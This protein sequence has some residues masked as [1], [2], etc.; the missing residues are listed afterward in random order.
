MSTRLSETE[1]RR[2]RE[3]ALRHLFLSDQ[4]GPQVLLSVGAQPGAGK[5]RAIEEVRAAFY[6]N[7]DL[8]PVIGDDLRAY[9]PD[10][11]RLVRDPDPLAMPA[12]T[13]DLS[14]WLVGQALDWA[15]EHGHSVLV[16]GTL[17]R[18]GTT[19][20]TLERFHSAGAIT[21][22]VVL[23]VPEA[24][25]WIGCL[26]RYLTSLARDGAARWTPQEAHDAGYTGTPATLA[27]A[28]A[29]AAVHRLSVV[30][31]T[32]PSPMTAPAT[33]QTGLGP[34]R[35]CGLWRSCAP[36][37]S[38]SAGQRPA[39]SSLS[40]SPPT[41]EWAQPSARDWTMRGRWSGLPH[42]QRLDP[43]YE[44]P[45]PVRCAVAR[46]TC[47]DRR[48]DAAGSPRTTSSRLARKEEVALDF[49]HADVDGEWFRV[50]VRVSDPEN[51]AIV[52]PVNADSVECQPAGAIPIITMSSAPFR[53]IR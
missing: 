38:R 39:L 29:T 45:E 2:A 46:R 30:A 15:A 5:T 44:W 13:A 48:L 52:T 22:L 24:V 23:G 25:S 18:P 33:P 20:S 51:D 16:E 7:H 3:R 1:R 32:A 47:V 34:T 19:L 37:P 9:H 11:A 42:H 17:R 10:Y 35:R 31:A 12:A 28:G 36:T 21:H 6:S 4:S 41:W 49:P 43:Q 14:G 40:R 53:Q 50:P 8:A 27:A 26:D